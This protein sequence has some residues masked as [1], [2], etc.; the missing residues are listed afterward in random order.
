MRRAVVHAARVAKDAPAIRVPSA[1]S[2][3][4]CPL[5]VCLLLSILPSTYGTR[6]LS[7]KW[8]TQK[9]RKDQVQGLG[10]SKGVPFDEA[11]ALLVAYPTGR[12]HLPDVHRL[13]FRLAIVSKEANAQAVRPGWVDPFR[14][15]RAAVGVHFHDGSVEEDV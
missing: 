4:I 14:N 7:V 5:A 13:E 8:L 9:A 3:W 6:T 10:R 15:A 11:V 12:L 2:V 1:S